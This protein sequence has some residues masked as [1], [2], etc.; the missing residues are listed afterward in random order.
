MSLDLT[1]GP[2]PSFTVTHASIPRPITF[3]AR[4]A[5]MPEIREVHALLAVENV[6]LL[7]VLETLLIA[8]DATEGEADS[9][10]PFSRE[11]FEKLSIKYPVVYHLVVRWLFSLV[12]P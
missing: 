6:K 11:N 10:L 2:E 8:W 1:L 12:H 7:E 4:W 9:P 5:H 3:R